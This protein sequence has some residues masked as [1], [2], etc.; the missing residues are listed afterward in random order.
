MEENKRKSYNIIFSFF[1]YIV[2]KNSPFEILNEFLIKLN[3]DIIEKG[4]QK[5]FIIFFIFYRLLFS[6]KRCY[7]NKEFY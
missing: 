5:K 3:Q 2:N 6:Q 4:K 1:H 7:F